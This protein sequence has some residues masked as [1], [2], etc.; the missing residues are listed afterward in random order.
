MKF[1]AR[2]ATSLRPNDVIALSGDLGAGKTTFVKGLAKGM[3]LCDEE[4][5]TSPTFSYLN[6]YEGTTPLFHFDLYRLSS[7]IEFELSGFQDYF[8]AGGITCI[9]WPN[10]AIPCLPK[11]TFFIDLMH[12]GAQKREILMRRY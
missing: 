10:C 4:A 8:C 7:E 9:E 3:G 11:K 6:I 1:A 5:I 2:L 12:R